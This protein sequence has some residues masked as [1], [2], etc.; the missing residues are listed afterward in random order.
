MASRNQEAT[1]QATVFSPRNVGPRQSAFGSPEEASDVGS[2]AQ[3]NNLDSMS[4]AYSLD[5]GLK[6]SH[7]ASSNAGFEVEHSPSSRGLS[8]PGSDS[9]PGRFKMN[10]VF[11]GKGKSNGTGAVSAT[12]ATELRSKPSLADDDFS[13]LTGAIEILP[14]GPPSPSK[15]RFGFSSLRRTNKRYKGRPGSTQTRSPTALPSPQ[16]PDSWLNEGN[17]DLMGGG[18]NSDDKS[19]ASGVS[20]LA[21]MS[22]MKSRIAS[23]P[24]GRT[25]RSMMD[26]DD[27]TLATLDAARGMVKRECWAPP[28]KLGVVIDSTKKGPVVHEVKAGSPLEGVVF[29]GDR[30]IAVDDNDTRS[31]TASAV[32]KVMAKKMDQRRKITVLSVVTGV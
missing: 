23:T 7:S 26:A 21:D 16:S 14:N 29:P 6:V 3:L 19:L 25:D 2:L 13:D 18:G 31:M 5:D 30:I 20:S 11:K 22:L 32:T 15:N 24:G 28:G 27:R 9:M 12:G 8:T 4:Y 17:D 1:P 10:D